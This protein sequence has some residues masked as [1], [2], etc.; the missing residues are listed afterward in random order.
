MGAYEEARRAVIEADKDSA[1][2]LARRHL[3][4]G[5][6]PLDIINNGFVP[7][8]TEVGER[9]GRGTLFLPE[10][11]MSAEVMMAVTD[12]LGEA[13]AAGGGGGGG[14]KGGGA[15]E[16]LVATVK[17]DV[18]DIG[19]GI[20]VAMFKANGYVVHDLGRDVEVDDIIES[21]ERLG[22]KVIATSALLT[23][24]MGEQKKLEETLKK[25]KIRD[26]YVTMVAGAP[27][28]RRWAARIGADIYAENAHTGVVRVRERLGGAA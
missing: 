13:M 7:G 23:T 20:A 16:I 22:V 6:S 10:L 18:H 9:F 19:K 27:V 21:A 2:D 1:L 28:T 5:G 26:R 17:G 8:I 14:A 3:D 25:A 11:I 24:T 4:G 12:L 15:D